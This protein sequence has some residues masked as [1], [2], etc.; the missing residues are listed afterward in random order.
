MARKIELPDNKLNI[1]VPTLSRNIGLKRCAEVY[2]EEFT[3]KSV[4]IWPVRTQWK[5]P[6]YTVT[7]YP[8]TPR[9]PIRARMATEVIAYYFK[10]EFGY[11]FVGYKADEDQDKKDRIFLLLEGDYRDEEYNAVGAI[12]FRWRKYSDAPEQRVLDWTW[13]HP[14]LRGTGIFTDYW[15]IFRDI[16]GDFRVEPPHSKAMHAFLVKMNALPFMMIRKEGTQ[17]TM[18]N[19]TLEH[20]F[21]VLEHALQDDAPEAQEALRTIKH[22][23][24]QWQPHI[25]ATTNQQRVM[26][27]AEVV[28][29]SWDTPT[30]Q[31]DLLSREAAMQIAT[32]ASGTIITA[33]DARQWRIISATIHDET[34]EVRAQCIPADA[35]NTASVKF[36]EN[37]TIMQKAQDDV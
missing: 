2:P 30:A 29:A 35:D 25:V 1:V 19:T 36:L 5:G 32:Q 8:I 37:E 26:P 21:A 3:G 31:G 28:I 4:G 16:Y 13:I 7:L 11:D 27:L 12:V 23:W 33:P 9:T 17:A 10:R 15:N 6:R 24:Q 34:R 14:F 20:A 18:T 22:A